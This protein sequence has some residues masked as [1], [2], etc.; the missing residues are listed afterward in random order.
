MLVAT[1][2]TNK[3][4]VGGLLGHVAAGSHAHA[5]VRPIEICDAARLRNL[6]NFTWQKQHFL[7]RTF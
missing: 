7:L 5:D 4:N 3:H 2:L 1:T 6:N